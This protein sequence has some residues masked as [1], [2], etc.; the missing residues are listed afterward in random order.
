MWVMANQ[1]DGTLVVIERMNQ[2]FPTLNVQVIG[3]L[4]QNQNMRRINR[5]IAINR[6]AF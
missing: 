6:R 1:N 3:W 2:C 5:P 4:I